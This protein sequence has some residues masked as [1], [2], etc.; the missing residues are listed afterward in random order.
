[1][2]GW[3]RVGRFMAG[4]EYPRGYEVKDTS[5]LLGRVLVL[6]AC[7]VAILAVPALATT[8]TPPKKGVYEWEA[9]GADIQLA[10]LSAHSIYVSNVACK[11]NFFTVTSRHEAMAKLTNDHFVFRF[12]LDKTHKPAMI[13]GT[14]VGKRVK[15]TG[16]CGNH[17]ATFRGT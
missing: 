13:A 6:A 14:F 11:G 10:V 7:I 17:I 15:L 5:P 1:M 12:R 4:P 16:E 3:L 8:T 9:P 2:E